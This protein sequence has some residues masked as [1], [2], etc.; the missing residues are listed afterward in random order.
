MYSVRP[1]S[2]PMASTDPGLRRTL[3]RREQNS[4][5]KKESRNLNLLFWSLTISGSIDFWLRTQYSSMYSSLQHHVSDCHFLPEWLVRS[6]WRRTLKKLNRLFLGIFL[7]DTRVL[8]AIAARCTRRRQYFSFPTLEMQ[9]F[10]D[11]HRC[12]GPLEAICSDHKRI[13]LNVTG[14]HN[15]RVI[16]C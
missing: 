7:S 4:M 9:F 1:A 3:K 10:L 11:L 16:S 2:E 12:F 13:F 6:R 5:G 15:R 8:I 14:G